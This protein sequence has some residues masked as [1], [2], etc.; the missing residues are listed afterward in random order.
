MVAQLCNVEP[1]CH[2]YIINLFDTAKNEVY[3][4]SGNETINAFVEHQ[5]LTE[6]RLFIA[7]CWLAV[8]GGLLLNLLTILVLTL[9]KKNSS[10]MRVQ[11]VNLAIADC[12]M[13]LVEPQVFL[14]HRE[15]ISVPIA[16]C[17]FAGFAQYCT[18][19]ISTLCNTAIS[20]D[21][22]TAVYYP[23]KFQLYKTHH[24]IL[25]ALAIWVIAIGIDLG[26]LINCYIWVIYEFEWCFCSPVRYTSQ[27]Y[28]MI[29]E[30]IIRF[31]K[32][33]VPAF[34]IML[35]YLLVGA[36]IIRWKRANTSETRRQK[37]VRSD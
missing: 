20:V 1:A 25:T 22:F 24:K 2:E 4:S 34:V 7:Y 26:T 11:L 21:R 30:Q 23:I 14:A 33:G 29:T 8:I 15:N 28:S 3:H 5:F 16:L 17:K 31:S 36:K 27:A 13:A 32:Y 19:T 18:L 9:G 35:M 37:K 10:E 12:F 6:D